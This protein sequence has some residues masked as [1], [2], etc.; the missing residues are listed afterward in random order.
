MPL[1]EE[2]HS[3]CPCPDLQ[4]VHIRGA[5]LDFGLIGRTR[6]ARIKHGACAFEPEITLDHYRADDMAHVGTPVFEGMEVKIKSEDPYQAGGID[7]EDAA[8]DLKM[9][10]VMKH[11]IFTHAFDDSLFDSL[12]HWQISWL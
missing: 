6:S 3:L 12:S 7:F 11:D 4:S 8:M 5:S 1:E 9:G 10:S 2:H